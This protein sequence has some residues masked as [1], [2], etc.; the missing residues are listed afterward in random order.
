MA[1]LKP[2]VN[3]GF[4]CMRFPTLPEGGIDIEQVKQMVDLFLERGFVYFDTAFAYGGSEEALKEALVKRHPRDSFLLATKCSLLGEV[5]KEE[6]E[7]RIFTSLERLGTDYVDF[8]LL[9]NV[10][11]NTIE[12]MEK[13]DLWNYARGLKEKG[14]IRK[15]GFSSHNDAETLDKLLTAHPEVDFVQLQINYIDWESEDVQ[16]RK[17]L[18]VARKHGKMVIV[19]EPCKG[20]SL[21]NFLPEEAKKLF[22]EAN[23]DASFASWALRYVASQEGVG[24]ILSGMSTLAQVEDNTT[25]MSNI[26]PMT[27][28][29]FAVVGKVVDVIN[30]IPLIPCT[31]CRY[32]MSVCP[33]EIP[34]PS[35][36]KLLNGYTVFPALQSS[37]FSYSINTKN[38]NKASDCLKC[39]LC[40]DTCPQNIAIRDYLD[41][42]AEL[43]E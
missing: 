39:G 13:H 2:G 43:F 16:S 26:T 12:V 11:G 19:M 33:Q 20:G 1:E 15:F 36:L 38:T 35:I 42:A 28:D 10:S 32:C 8:Y 22:T 3:F 25:F 23:P 7:Q 27:E 9:H 14:I 40:E 24:I 37:R 41:K 17:C 21:A 31:T 18:E 34:I 30:S 6:A 5:T 4:G 29:E